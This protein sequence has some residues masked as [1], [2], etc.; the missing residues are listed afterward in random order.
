MRNTNKKIITILLIFCLIL[1]IFPNL[2]QPL[3]AADISD[4]LQITDFI[5]TN[6]DTGSVK[7]ETESTARNEY[8]QLK[9]SFDYSGKPL[10]KGDKLYF[11]LTQPNPQD[12][13]TLYLMGKLGN[14]SPIYNSDGIKIAEYTFKNNN[15]VTPLTSG[16]FEITML[17]DATKLKNLSIVT[18]NKWIRR[19]TSKTA[20]VPGIKAK[21]KIGNLEKLFLL[22]DEIIKTGLGREIGT[23]VYE[24]T[25][26]NV[27]WGF[28]IHG[29]QQCYNAMPKNTSKKTFANSLAE[30][31]LDGLKK[32][33]DPNSIK[34]SLMTGLPSHDATGISSLLFSSK[35]LKPFFKKIEQIPNENYEQ[36]K[37]RVKNSGEW[38]WGI[39]NH[40]NSSSSIVI[41]QGTLLKAP[42]T[43]EDLIISKNTPT[44]VDYLKQSKRI[45][46]TISPEQENL[47]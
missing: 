20:I 1:S 5:L 4:G 9:I 45:I 11:K 8:L 18:G 12:I 41:Y 44:F 43:Y 15:N 6:T 2:T 39:F 22:E 28:G 23:Y 26:S 14:P 19:D 25:D 27:R 10:T 31:R 16:I 21:I 13:G 33:I 3:Y 35:N 46:G 37:L 24:I 47:Y 34:I 36:F 7:S 38:S 29:H 42:Y 40:S 17:K 32:P 30:T